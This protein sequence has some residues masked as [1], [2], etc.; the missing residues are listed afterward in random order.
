MGIGDFSVAV[1]SLTVS[2]MGL[3]TVIPAD[4]TVL[5]PPKLKRNWKVTEGFGIQGAFC[6]Y[7]GEGLATFDATF[8]FWNAEMEILWNA[9]ASIFLSAPKGVKPSA[10]GIY[11]PILVTAPFRIQNVQVTDLEGWSLISPGKWQTKLS[12]LEYRPPLPFKP[13]KT[14]PVVPAVDKVP[15]AKPKTEQDLRMAASAAK[16]QGAVDA[17]KK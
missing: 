5:S 6:V 10:L 16:L 7:T 13:V 3:Q 2:T 12:F 4:K 14:E 1:D 8:E 11:H 17:G 9:F 15:I